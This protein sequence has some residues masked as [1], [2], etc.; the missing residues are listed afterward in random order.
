[1]FILLWMI[2]K[3]HNLIIKHRPVLPVFR[4]TQNMIWV[5]GC[6]VVLRNMK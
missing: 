2:G 5:L 1:M 3:S 6:F 4:A